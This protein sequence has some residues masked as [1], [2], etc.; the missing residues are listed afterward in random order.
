MALNSQS[1]HPE[2]RAQRCVCAVERASKGVRPPAGPSSFE[3]R[4]SAHLRMTGPLSR[5]LPREH[6]FQDLAADVL[7]GQCSLM[8]PPAVALHL[9]AC[10]DESIRDGGKIRIGVIQAED[11]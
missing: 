6:L 11:Q 10:G 8:P 2:V 4:K 9:F 1:R 3:A 7:V 5:P